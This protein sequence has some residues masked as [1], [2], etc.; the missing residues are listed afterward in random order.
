ME[1]Q[2]CLVEAIYHLHIYSTRDLLGYES[3]H[4]LLG[5]YISVCDGCRSR[6]SSRAISNISLRIM[7]KV[8]TFSNPDVHLMLLRDA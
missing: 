7:Y 8:A 3:I 6:H 2:G 5:R 1:M 4:T